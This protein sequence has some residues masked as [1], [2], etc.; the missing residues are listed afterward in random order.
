MVYAHNNPFLSLFLHVW[1]T[2]YS[3]YM[4]GDE[5][6]QHA[7]TKLKAYLTEHQLPHNFELLFHEPLSMDIMRSEGDR[8]VKKYIGV[9][10]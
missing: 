1:Q 3:T 4:G 7:T 6:Q 5:R 10:F 2:K 9:A 8:A